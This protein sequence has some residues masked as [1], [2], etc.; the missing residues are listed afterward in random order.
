MGEW[1]Q[2]EPQLESLSSRTCGLQIPHIQQ[3]HMVSCSVIAVNT[4]NT[5]NIM[6]IVIITAI[7]IAGI[8]IIVLLLIAFVSNC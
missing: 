4:T 7:T 6:N 2:S 1:G 3:Y 8:V 5:I